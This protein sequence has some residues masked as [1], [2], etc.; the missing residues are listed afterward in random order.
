MNQKYQQVPDEQSYED[1]NKHQ[2][3][4]LPG[5]QHSHL[6]ANEARKNHYDCRLSEKAAKRKAARSVRG[7]WFESTI[8][9]HRQCS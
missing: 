7:R 2:S 1:C 9:A 5:R 6:P 4:S 8:G 3:H